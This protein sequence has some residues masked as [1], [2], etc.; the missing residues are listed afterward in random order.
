MTALERPRVEYR[1]PVDL[2]SEVTK[3]L[4]RIPPF[5][6]GF[7]WE[8]GDI[9]KLFDSLVRG[10]PIGNLLFWRRPAGRQLLTVGPLTIDAAATD[11]AMWVVDGQQR[12]TSLVGAL[13]AAHSST[14]SRFRVHLDLGSGEFHTLGVRQSVP[15]TWL[16][17]SVLLDTG[18]LLGWMRENADW[19]SAEQIAVADQ[20]AKAVREYQIPTYVVSSADEASLVEIFARMNTTGKP[21]TRTEVFQALHSGTSGDEPADLASVARIGAD[22]GFGRLDER[23][24]L[25]CLL[26]YRGGDIFREDV[27]GEF[28]SDEDRRETFRGVASAVRAAVEF[29]QRVAGIPHVKL[30]PYSHVLPI[31]VRY[32]RLYGPP[33]GRSSTLLRRWVWRGAVAG[34][35]ARGISVPD[36]RDQVTMLETRDAFGAAQALLQAVRPV[37]KFQ[38]EIDKVN[39][40]HAMA[41]INV[42][43]LLSADP[44]DLATGTSYDLATLLS[45]GAPLRTVVNDETIPFAGTMANRIIGA[46]GSGRTLQAALVAADDDL[47]AGHLVDLPARRALAAGDLALFLTRRAATVEAAVQRHVAHMA[48]WGARDGRAVSEMLRSVA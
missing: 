7:K 17:V 10:Y 31:V 28:T 1:T 42:L 2:V 3:G 33:A 38:P 23:V 36:I 6:R 13:V 22:M 12:I 37:P 35:S 46:T 43:A 21:L 40:S 32:V 34:A 26:A 19:L 47:C 44:R 11:A 48:E 15:V 14:D 5:Q 18:T 39:F 16:P 27:R 25:R 45:R 8:A 4:V 9:V 24:V 20:A 30:L 41:K 29:L